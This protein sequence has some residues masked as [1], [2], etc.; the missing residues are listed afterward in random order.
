MEANGARRGHLASW[1][2][3]AARNVSIRSAKVVSPGFNSESEGRALS[4]CVTTRIKIL[5]DV[6]RNSLKY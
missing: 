1:R 4:H 6:C 5:V 2:Y 3:R